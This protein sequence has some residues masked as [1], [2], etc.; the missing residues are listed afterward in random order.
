MF[1]IDINSLRYILRPRDARESRSRRHVDWSV[2]DVKIGPFVIEMTQSELNRA[3]QYVTAITS[4]ARDTVSD[5][6]RTGL[7]ELAVLVTSSDR[8][9]ERDALVGYMGAWTIKRTGYP[10]ALAR[11]VLECANRWLD[12]EAAR[13]ANVQTELLDKSDPSVH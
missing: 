1:S 10:E 4:Y 13:L 5:I 3:V 11:E 12:A 2:R 8:Q 6:L 9:F 7:G